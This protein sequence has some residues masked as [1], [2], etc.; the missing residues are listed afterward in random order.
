MRGYSWTADR[1]IADLFASLREERFGLADPAVYRATISRQ[2]V[3]AYINESGRDEQEFLVWPRYLSKPERE[4]MNKKKAERTVCAPLHD[5]CRWEL[6]T[7][8]ATGYLKPD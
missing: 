2:H 1:S 6:I 7:R 8:G 4:G 3:I 5:M